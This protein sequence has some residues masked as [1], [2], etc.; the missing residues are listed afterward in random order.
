MFPQMTTPNVA[1]PNWRPTF[2]DYLYVSV[3]NV[4]AF[5][6]TDTMPL[7]RWAKS[8]DDR[9]GDGGAVYGRAR[10][11]K[12]GER[13]GLNV[14]P[15]KRSTF[16]SH[17]DCNNGTD[18]RREDRI[19]HR[20]R[21]GAGQPMAET[22]PRRHAGARGRRQDRLRLQGPR[23]S[24][25]RALPNRAA[26]KDARRPGA[27]VRRE[28]IPTRSSSTW[29]PGW[30][31]ARTGWI[32]RQSVDWYSVDLPGISAL[33]DEVLPARPHAHTVP[34]SLADDRWPDAI[35]ADRPTDA[36]RRRTVR[37]SH[38]TGDRRDLP[39]DHRPLRFG[40]AGVQRL[41][42]HRLGQP[43]GDQAVPAEDVQ[44]RRKPVGA[45]TDS[46]TRTI[47]RPGIRGCGW[48]RR[49]A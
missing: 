7:A 48:S 26:R 2:V 14:Q 18:S 1:K 13:F 36:D 4:M 22:D 3:T 47:R 24:D 9:A 10:N 40:R 45:T 43:A 8:H 27:R 11:L 19:S 33:R 15:G 17:G 31:A 35:P 32:R 41:R 44:G 5:S 37:V 30:T 34:V 42:R 39:P 6:P 23:H 28:A 38:R 25:Q 46:R 49:P 16:G 29:A 21:Q 20:V 12:G